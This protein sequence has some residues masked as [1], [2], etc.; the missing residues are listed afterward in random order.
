MTILEKF[1]K[2]SG[3]K[4]NYN[5]SEALAVFRS[6]RLKQIIEQSTEEKE[7][8]RQLNQSLQNHIITTTIITNATSHHWYDIFLGYS[9]SAKKMLDWVIHPLLVVMVIVIMLL[10]WNCYMAYKV[11]CRRPKVLMVTYGNG[12]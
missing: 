4:V 5:K 1:G 12:K 11:F 7:I 2:C 10:I 8:I 6:G 9:P 3:F